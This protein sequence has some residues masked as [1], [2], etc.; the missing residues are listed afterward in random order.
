VQCDTRLC[1]NRRRGFDF[2]VSSA[3]FVLT[4]LLVQRKMRDFSQS[5]SGLRRARLVVGALDQG[6]W[7]CG[8]SFPPRRGPLADSSSQRK[9]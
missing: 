1:G 6:A 9:L 8:G 5:F 4:G 2:R 7:G 3:A